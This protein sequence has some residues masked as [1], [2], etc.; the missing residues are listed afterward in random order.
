MLSVIG[1]NTNMVKPD[2][3]PKGHADLL[4]PKW[5]GKLVKAHPGYSGTIMTATQQ[6]VRDLGWPYFEK[7]AQQSVM[8]V[9]SASDTPK[10][11]SLGER[12]VK[13]DGNEYNCC[14][15]KEQG[16]PVEPVYAVEGTPQI[17]GPNG[18]FK[19]AP[20]PNAARLF[21]NWSFTAEC[22]QLIID[23]GGAA[24][25]APAGQGKARP[26]AARGHQD[27]QGRRRRGREA[28]RRDQE[29]IQPN[30][31]GVE[32]HAMRHDHDFTRR[33]ILK[34]G[35]RACAAT[36]FAEPIRAQAPAP[37]AITPALIEAAKKEG[38]VVCYTAMDLAVAQ[39]L[40]KAF[41]AKYPGIP[42]RVER[43]G[44]ER[45]FQR[46]GQ[47]HTAQ[48]PRR[49][50]R[51]HLRRGALHRL[52]AQRLAR[53]LSAGGSRQALSTSSTTIRTGCSS[54]TRV[55]V[56]PIG[57]NTNLVKTEEAPKSFADL[58]DPKWAGKMVKAHPAYSGTIMNSTYQI[59][60]DL[61]W[62]YFEK[63]A[64]QRV[65]QVQSATDP[66]KK[67]ALGE[68]AVMVDGAGYFIIRSRKRASRSR[69]SIRPRARRWRR[70]ERGVQE[71]A[72][73]ERRAAVPELDAL[74]RG[75]A[76]PGRL[77]AAVFAA[78]ADR[79]KAGRAAAEG[80]QA[81]EGRRRC[82]REERPRRSRSA[83][84]RYFKV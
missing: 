5:K 73:S 10:K 59:A 35:H 13:A 41:E 38:K 20:N 55:L 46:I 49:R 19:T 64:K 84:R 12:A 29:T 50:R 31:Q 72:Q 45:I 48:H 74:A 11:I 34:G 7:L 75:A 76:V 54:A 51:Q 24:L 40:G 8:Q 6:L 62:D 1:Y 83:T 39:R 53:A 47:E 15:L 68:R 4:D 58:L 3:A 28:E 71:R 60:R 42:V 78:C 17:V 80:H 14:L 63:L 33:N 57:Y 52:E 67:I 37:A 70:P 82:G 65:M 22:Q 25:A 79:G 36:V 23:V 18:I 9:Q 27:P 32:E 61:G 21:Q 2:E 56:S 81:D 44:A 66:P 77:G 26:Q 69:S 16:Q 43:S 30:I